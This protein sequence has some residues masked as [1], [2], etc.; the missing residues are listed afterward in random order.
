M[1]YKEFKRLVSV[2]KSLRNAPRATRIGRRHAK[3]RAKGVGQWLKTSKVRTET[4][5][6][7]EY[8][9]VHNRASAR[10]R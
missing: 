10:A 5:D 7:L 6:A 3:G 1:D 8:N 2:S 4:F 9:N